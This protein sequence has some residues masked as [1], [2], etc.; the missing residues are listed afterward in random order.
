MLQ[1]CEA[2]KR[3]F[4]E[5]YSGGAIGAKPPPGPVKSIDFRGFSGQKKI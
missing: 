2:K 5:A 4:S 1:N 3:L